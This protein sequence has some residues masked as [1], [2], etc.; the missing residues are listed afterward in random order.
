MK[1]RGFTLIELLTVVAI[2]GIL[3]SIGSYTYASSLA[4]SRDNQR[5]TD[6]NLIKNA[7][8]QYYLENRTYPLFDKLN[9]AGSKF[10]FVAAWQLTKDDSYSCK[11]STEYPP[12]AN[13]RFLAPDYLMTIPEDPKKKFNFQQTCLS[14]TSQAGQYLYLSLP[15]ESEGPNNRFPKLP[16]TG[17]YLA[18]RM[19]R[20][21]NQQTFSSEPVST[22]YVLGEAQG[23]GLS[24]K[25]ISPTH[26]YLLKN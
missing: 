14:I 18:A 4:R 11:H 5:L 20:P 16:T 17:Y 15:D 6:L 12:I 10:I 13:Q 26:N 3:V 22:Y 19:E 7:L 25:G 1:R 8:E 2:I 23:G 24:F 9:T 21:V